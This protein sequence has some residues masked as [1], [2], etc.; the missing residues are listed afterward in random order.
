M[1]DYI[2]FV[3]APQ[4][5]NGLTIG[6]AII[7]VSLG[8]SIIFGLLDVVN[9]AHGEFYALGAFISMSLYSLGLGFWFAL[10]VTP[11]IVLPIG[12][13]LER[14]LI[15]LVY[16]RPA[17]HVQTLLLTIGI[18]IML[19]DLFDMIYGPNTMRPDSPISGVARL[20]DIIVPNYRL[21]LMGFGTIV[22]LL[23]WYVLF[24]TKL[25]SV[26]RAAAYDK[27]MTASLGVPVKVIYSGAFAF[28]TALAALAGVLLAPIYSVFPTMGQDFILLAFTVVIVGGIG[29]FW[30]TVVAGLLL[31]QIESLSALFIPPNWSEPLVFGIM[32]AVLIFRPQ[33]LF[34]WNRR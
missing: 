25:G 6:V 30:G 3:L 2:E 23:T 17:R 4:V 12:V 29:S 10:V 14:G 11:L 31:T 21:F 27:D 26:I 15:Q 9:M 19:K 13:L 16:H 7:L 34:S 8:L 33:G 32:I 1:I 24:R 5:V 28:G 22:I 20:G 18:S